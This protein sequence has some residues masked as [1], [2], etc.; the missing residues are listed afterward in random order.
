MKYLLILLLFLTGTMSKS[1]A[2]ES[3]II[4]LSEIKTNNLIHSKEF[5]IST[6][7]D[8]EIDVKVLHLSG[9]TLS[10]FILDRQKK[11]IAKREIVKEGESTLT[12]EMEKKD[13]YIVKIISEKPLG[14]DLR[15]V[16]K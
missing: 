10:V 15:L 8:L 13:E 2:Q 12:F 1:V 3:T 14:I 4:A 9:E 6:N 5:K 7:E 11:I 16:Q